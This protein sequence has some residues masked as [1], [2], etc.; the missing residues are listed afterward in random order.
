MNSNQQTDRQYDRQTDKKTESKT[1]RQI[2]SLTVTDN[3]KASKKV[4]D[5]DKGK[6]HKKAMFINLD[7][8]T[9]RHIERATDSQTERKTDQQTDKQTRIN[10]DIDRQKQIS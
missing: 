2:Y 9:D 4:Q 6:S 3:D 8:K 10:Q 1:D 5:I 7:R